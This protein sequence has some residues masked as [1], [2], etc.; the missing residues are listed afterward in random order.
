[1]AAPTVKIESIPV[2]FVYGEIGR[3]VAVTGT[4]VESPTVIRLFFDNGTSIAET[5]GTEFVARK[6][7]G[8]IVHVYADPPRDR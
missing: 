4:I 6:R 8:A 5:R 1:M 7:R 3:G 2:P